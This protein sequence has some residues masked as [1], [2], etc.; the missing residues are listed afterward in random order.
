MSNLINLYNLSMYNLNMWFTVYWFKKEKEIVSIFFR[1][2][3]GREK[4]A[5]IN[6]PEQMYGHQGGKVMGGRGEGW[7][8]RLGLT[9]IH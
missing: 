6:I 9:Y 1:S 8:G 2:S 3:E 5:L 7:I 4:I